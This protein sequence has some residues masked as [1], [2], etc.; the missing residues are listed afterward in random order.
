MCNE[1]INDINDNDINMIL[2]LLLILMKVI[3]NE[4]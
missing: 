4:K 3:S 1:I 2:I